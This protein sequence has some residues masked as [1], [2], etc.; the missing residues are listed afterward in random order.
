MV[1]D[2]TL[3]TTRRLSPVDEV[4]SVVSRVGNA[5]FW[6]KTTSNLD[7]D[8]YVLSEKALQPLSSHKAVFEMEG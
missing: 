6:V 8:A 4:K 5:S 7:L 1:V 2:T 3:S